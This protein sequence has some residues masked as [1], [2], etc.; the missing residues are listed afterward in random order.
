VAVVELTSLYLLGLVLVVAQVVVEHLVEVLAALA[1]QDKEIM[2][3]LAALMLLVGLLVAAAVEQVQ[4]VVAE[5]Q[6]RLVALAV[7][8]QLH[9]LQ[10]HL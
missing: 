5:E 7:Q 6:V 10:E 8:V 2:A 4:L 3:A 1:R 9:Q